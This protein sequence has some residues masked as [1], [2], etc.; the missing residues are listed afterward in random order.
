ME[1]VFTTVIGDSQIQKCLDGEMVSEYTL[2][3]GEAMEGS[4]YRLTY[5]PYWELRGEVIAYKKPILLGI[6]FIANVLT[7]KG[8]FFYRFKELDLN[9]TEVVFE[10]EIL[11]QGAARQAALNALLKRIELACE[12]S[13]EALKKAAESKAAL[14]LASK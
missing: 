7:T 9:K 11:A 5:W 13:I 10:L 2:L 4:K 3:D 14:A 8:T 6:G 12:A 1:E